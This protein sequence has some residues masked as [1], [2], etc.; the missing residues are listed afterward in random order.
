MKHMVTNLN[1]TNEIVMF[2]NF[3]LG[4]F[5]FDTFFGEL[6][7]E[8]SPLVN[9]NKQ[10][11]LLHT[12]QVV[13]PHCIIVDTCTKVDSNNCIDVVSSSTNFS[14][15]LTNPHIWILYFDGSKN[16]E[17]VGA[18]SLLIDPH[19][20]KTMLACHLAFDCTKNVVEYEA[21]LQG[22]RKELDLQFKC[23]EI[24]GDL[25]VVI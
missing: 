12:T 10:S 23:I 2:S 4:N 16:K 8:L 5:Y 1:D 25:Q 24:F 15:E 20:N 17:G 11:D 13:K 14:V 19:G 9:S 6:E 18:G 22:P 21:L 3:I 7:D